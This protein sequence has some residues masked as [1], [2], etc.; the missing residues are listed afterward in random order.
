MTSLQRICLV[1]A[2]LAGFASVLAGAHA[3]HG[4]A[5]PQ[6]RDW[7][8]TGS[9]YG[10]LQALAVFAA[11]SMATRGSRSSMAAA[12]L[13]LVGILLFCGSLWA[14]AMG[15]P[16]ALATAKP[17]GGIAFLAGWLALAWA[18]LTLRKPA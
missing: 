11:V 10:L 13:F 12:I 15:A 17:V 4:V 5:D 3:A 8:R 1:L 7:M 9:T 14:I 2:A 6:A 16:K 18:C